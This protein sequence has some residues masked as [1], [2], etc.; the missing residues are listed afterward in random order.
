[1]KGNRGNQSR[2]QEGGLDK[3]LGDRL[4]VGE[5]DGCGDTEDGRSRSGRRRH[6]GHTK[7][8]VSKNQ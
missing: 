1:M 5:T 2:G 4:D 8:R 6:W 7:S 3:G